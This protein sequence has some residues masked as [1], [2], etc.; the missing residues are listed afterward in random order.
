LSNQIFAHRGQPQTPAD[1]VEEPDPKLS[2]K[3][4]NLTRGRRL[5]QVE[6]TRRASN[7]ADFGNI[8][9]GV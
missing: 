4:E 2:L 7:A 9:E 1:P 5:T 8:H 6:P 3:R